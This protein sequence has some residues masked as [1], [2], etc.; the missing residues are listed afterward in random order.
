MRAAMLV[1]AGAD[2]AVAFLKG[3]TIPYCREL[4]K[5]DET[6]CPDNQLDLTDC[7]CKKCSA[8]TKGQQD[9]YINSSTN[10]T[11]ELLNQ[12][13]HPENL[14]FT[15]TRC[16]KGLC[17]KAMPFPVGYYAPTTSL[18]HALDFSMP[19]AACPVTSLD[20]TCRGCADACKDSAPLFTPPEETA[21]AT[22]FKLSTVACPKENLFQGDCRNCKAGGCKHAADLITGNALGNPKD[23]KDQVQ[24]GL[25]GGG[26]PLKFNGTKITT[27]SNCTCISFRLALKLPPL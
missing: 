7:G 3:N 17:A 9:A 5:I 27:P 23:E 12:S 24:C 14:D 6:V 11:E 15:C 2:N 1:L 26:N 8:W 25:D 4:T 10:F 20:S 16:K 19:A 22:K 13:C 18:S 21:P